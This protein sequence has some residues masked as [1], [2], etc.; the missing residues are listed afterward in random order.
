MK[1]VS[2]GKLIIS[3]EHSVAYGAPAIAMAIDRNAVFEVIPQLDKKISF[4]LPEFKRHSYTLLALRDLKK[5]VE[6]KYSQF[7]DGE[8]G[9]GYVL[10]APADLFRFAFIH[11]LD[12]LH[13]SLDSGVVMKLQS[14][15]PVG[16]GMGSSA[17]TVLSELRA[18]GHYLRVDF[19]PEWYYEYSLEVE[20]LQHGH[21]S[22][23]DSYMALNGGCAYFKNGSGKKLPLLRQKMYLVETGKPDSSTGS[24]VEAV[25][26]NFASSNIWSEFDDITE[27]LMNDLKSN[28]QLK[29]I[30]GI[31]ENHQLLKKISVVPEKVEKFINEIE[32]LGGAAKISGA[33]SVKGNNAGAVLVFCEKPPIDLCIEY[34]Y[35][36][37][38]VRGDPLGTRII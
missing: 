13:R 18:L 15:I 12:S 36:I 11:A 16:C 27:S 8:I 9:I 2:P 7:L 37:S 10:S 5:R 35:T 22:G 38:T 4:D 6:R 33:G 14:T 34:G 1:A 23:I 28:N 3:G 17:A 29:I 24:C 32:K 30:K 21:P 31:R 19:K 20:R 26:K 25:R